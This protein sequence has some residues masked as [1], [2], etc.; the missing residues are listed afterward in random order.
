VSS[1][2]DPSRNWS[3]KTPA[4]RGRAASSRFSLWPP[5]ESAN[6]HA[7]P[8]VLRLGSTGPLRS[9]SCSFFVYEQGGLSAHFQRKRR[10]AIRVSSGLARF[11]VS[12]AGEAVGL[13]RLARRSSAPRPEKPGPGVDRGTAVAGGG[14]GSAPTTPTDQPFRNLPPSPSGRS[15]AASAHHGSGAWMAG[16]GL[17][18]LRKTAQVGRACSGWPEEAGLTR[19]RFRA[20]QLGG[21]N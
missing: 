14:R 9:P 20:P 8:S 4:A 15:S 17:A 1:T 10:H 19:R 7:P 2:S 5:A 3:F 6:D 12:R 13:A 21:Q 11:L 18:V 16:D